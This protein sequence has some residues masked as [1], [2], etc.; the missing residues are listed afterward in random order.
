M[1]Y[2]A[3]SLD[4]RAH[5]A[6]LLSKLGLDNGE[7]ETEAID[8]ERQEAS[9]GPPAASSHDAGDAEEELEKDPAEDDEEADRL[10]LEPLSLIRTIFPSVSNPLSR[11]SKD[12]STAVDPSV[13]MPWPPSTRI[14][15]D[16][17]LS[18]DED[19]LPETLDEK[20]LVDELLEERQLE[21]WDRH[22]DIEGERALWTRVNA[23]NPHPHIAA[24]IVDSD[25]EDFAIEDEQPK[26]VVIREPPLRKRKRKEVDAEAAVEVDTS[27]AE[28]AEGRNLGERKGAMAADV[29]MD[30]DHLEG[31]AP[32]RRRMARKGKLSQ[33]ALL[34]M[35]PGVDSR[36]KSSVYVLDSD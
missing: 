14:P 25:F 34:Y 36:I 35:Q 7:D 3:E 33:E 12:A 23:E 8:E 22:R 24:D 17:V 31:T 9:G 18:P 2:G 28:D 32:K 11:A 16:A 6:R 15:S 13:Y 21:K 30:L 29:P 10:L 27:R 20:L 19:I 5:F 4:K 1:L 26:A